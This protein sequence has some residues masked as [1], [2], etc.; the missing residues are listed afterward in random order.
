MMRNRRD[1]LDKVVCEIHIEHI[2]RAAEALPDGSGYKP[3]EE[4]ESRA[5]FYSPNKSI[6]RALSRVVSA[7]DLRRTMV[8]P[9][10]MIMGRHPPTDG[11]F[12]SA[13]NIPIINLIAGP[14]YLLS[15]DDVP[16]F[17]AESELERVVR[18]IADLAGELDGIPAAVLG[19]KPT[20]DRKTAEFLDLLDNLGSE[21][22]YFKRLSRLYQVER[23]F[24]R[25]RR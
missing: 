15:E 24:D 10:G 13:A 19:R 6:K 25:F 14:P 8:L 11:G 16:A 9:A 3:L 2:C 17:V 5:F 7:H 1:I 18:A 23:F 20:N 21:E 22:V 4:I 12:Y